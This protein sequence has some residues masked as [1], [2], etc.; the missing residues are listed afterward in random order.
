MSKWHGLEKRS[1]KISFFILKKKK[2]DWLQ[3]KQEEKHYEVQE[4]GSSLAKAG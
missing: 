3:Y 1:S 4:T 2:I